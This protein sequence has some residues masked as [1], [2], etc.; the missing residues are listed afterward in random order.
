MNKTWWI[1]LFVIVLSADIAG[2][3]LSDKTV[4]YISKPFIVV[5][6]IGYFITVTSINQ[7]TVK[8]W[9]LFALSLSWLGDMLLM[10]QENDEIFFLS[11]LSA[12][13]AA[14]I[15]YII[16]F[17]KVGKRE[18]LQR[19]LIILAIAIVYGVS[20]LK[21]LSPYLGEMKWPVRVYGVVI[22]IMFSMAMHMIFIKNKQAGYL[23]ATGALLFV[24]SD[25]ILALNKFYRSFE[26]AGVVIMLTYGLAQ[27][28]ITAGAIQYI[29][30][31]PV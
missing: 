3:L 6:L 23:L 4:Q 25:S 17:F 9:I 26:L 24:I 18:K 27:F 7:G 2:L 16:Y 10:F 28:L 14:H 1:V 21:F 5:S 22:T 20:I 15:C 29:R 31:R 30:K 8:R 11:G 12:F 13:L 19:N